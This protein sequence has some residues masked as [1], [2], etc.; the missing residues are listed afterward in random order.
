MRVHV[1]VAKESFGGLRL[2]RRADFN[3]AAHVNTFW[4]MPCRR[5]LDPAS[6][7]ALNWDNKHITW[8]GKRCARAHSV[9]DGDKDTSVNNIFLTLLLTFIIMNIPL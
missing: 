5:V 7:K 6:K 8:F 2:L 1:C 4:R 9:W 3:A